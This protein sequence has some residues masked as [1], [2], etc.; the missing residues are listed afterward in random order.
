MLKLKLQCIK[1]KQWQFEKAVFCAMDRVAFLRFE[2]AFC[3]H[4][5]MPFTIFSFIRS[6]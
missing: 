4:N 5:S 2:N 1:W 6:F 3:V